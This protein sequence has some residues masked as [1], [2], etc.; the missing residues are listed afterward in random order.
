MPREQREALKV[1]ALEK[2]ENIYGSAEATYQVIKNKWK[3]GILSTQK[4]EEKDVFTGIVVFTN[5]C[6]VLIEQRGLLSHS[7]HCRVNL[8]Y[9]SIVGVSG[10]G[11]ISKYISITD[12]NGIE[13]RISVSSNTD[14]ERWTI[15]IK[16]LIKQKRKLLEEKEKEKRVQVIM[17]FSFLKSFAKKGGIILNTIS[18]PN[19]NGVVDLPASGNI[20]K[21]NYCQ[22]QI[23]ATD[24]FEKMKDLLDGVLKK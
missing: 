5:Y 13:H 18:C 20:L 2:G 3:T 15:L 21:C 6:I 7:Y 4:I 16:Q 14:F 11:W 8:P 17:D 12:H 1:V 24:I 22:R 9:E 23:Y 19:C 10:G